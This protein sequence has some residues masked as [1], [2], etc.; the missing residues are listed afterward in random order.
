MAINCIDVAGEWPDNAH[1]QD[2]VQERPMLKKV[3]KAIAK[4]EARAKK[5]DAAQLSVGTSL[6]TQ[7]RNAVVD[8]EGRA[9][10]HDAA[11]A[12]ARQAEIGRA[13]CRERV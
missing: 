4:L 7:L 6:S 8:L 3:L 10:A 9:Q 5:S 13:S 11:A 2:P 1:S 12:A